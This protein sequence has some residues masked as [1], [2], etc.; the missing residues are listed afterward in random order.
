MHRHFFK[1]LFLLFLLLGCSV[2][3]LPTPQNKIERLTLLL[4]SLD[5]SVSYEKSS[6]LSRDIFKQ[7]EILT[8]R[9]KLTSPPLWHNFLVNTGLRN[10]GLCYHWSDALYLH[11][12]DKKYEDFSFYLVG[13]SIGNYFLEHNA[14]LVVAKRA[15]SMQGGIVIDPWRE[16]GKLYFSKV[17]EDTEYSWK[18]RKEREPSSPK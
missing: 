15:K 16:S 4:Q 7:I 1:Y 8:K 13:S 17:E 2:K 18:H 12:Y 11:L 14:L 10:K 5:S 3:L 6:M 9:F